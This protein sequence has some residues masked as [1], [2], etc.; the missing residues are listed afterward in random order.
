MGIV[1]GTVMAEKFPDPNVAVVRAIVQ[2]PVPLPRSGAAH[3]HATMIGVAIPSA[4]YRNEN[5]I[6]DALELLAKEIRSGTTFVSMRPTAA[7][8]VFDPSTLVER[9]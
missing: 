9:G 8:W 5:V 4:D 1:R 7:G 6:A 2:T 3:S